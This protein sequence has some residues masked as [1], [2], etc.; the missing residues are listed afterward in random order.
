MSQSKQTPTQV[1]I[2]SVEIVPGS[3]LVHYWKSRMQVIQTDK[4][5]FIDNM[6]GIKFTKN[7]TAYPGFDWKQFEGQVVDNFQ[8]ID[9]MGFQW[10]NKA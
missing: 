9:H 3:K 4:G 5:T 2:K 7:P 10:I 1:T 8:I 6:P